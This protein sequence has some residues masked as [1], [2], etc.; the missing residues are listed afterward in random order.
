M[1]T[2]PT[3]VAVTLPPPATVEFGNLCLGAGGGLTLGFWSNKNGKALFGADDLALMV[4]LNLRNA[5]GS[6]FDPATTPRSAPGC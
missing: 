3:S 1:A 4:S 5:S 2:T 6:N